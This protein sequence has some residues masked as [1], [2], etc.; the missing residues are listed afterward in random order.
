MRTAQCVRASAEK[1]DLFV[2][3]DFKHQKTVY[4]FNSNR[5]LETVCALLD[6]DPKH[7]ER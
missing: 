2:W 4:L 3:I 6:I 1:I 5:K 7:I